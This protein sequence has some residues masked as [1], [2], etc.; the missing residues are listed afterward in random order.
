MQEEINEWLTRVELLWRQKS[1]ETWLKE[2][3]KNSIF[4]HLSTIIRRKRNSIDAIKDDHGAWIT[5][6]KEIREMFLNKFEELFVEE[7]VDFP[8]DLENLVTQSISESENESLCQLPYAQEIKNAL[9]EMPTLKPPRPDGLPVLFYKKNI[10][11][12]L[13]TM[14]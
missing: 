4:F 12:Q 14:W 6:K 11:Q 5:E 7:D 9:C 1:R 8:E 13:V 10:G 3:D 2:G